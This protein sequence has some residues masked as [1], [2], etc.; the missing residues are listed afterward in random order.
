MHEAATQ[1]WSAPR[2]ALDHLWLSEPPV[3]CAALERFRQGALIVLAGDPAGRVYL[4]RQGR[5]R[6]YL[7]CS[8]KAETT[9]A[10]LGPAQLVGVDGLAGRA[11]Y[12]ASVAALTDV[13]L[14]AMP[15]E[16]LRAWLPGSPTLLRAL[17]EAL[18]RQLLLAETLLGDV[19]LG[20]VE[21][22]VPD[23]LARLAACLGPEEP[24]LSRALIAQLVGA[25]RETVSRAIR[26][27][28]RLAPTA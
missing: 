18:G 15:A 28:R 3:P 9:A 2:R 1:P 20:R 22:R 21:E 6:V 19:P 8:A 24:A 12:H 11:R 17:V 26:S 27:A 4:I 25:R 10:I 16:D 5:V 13:E 7:H 14:W 23:V